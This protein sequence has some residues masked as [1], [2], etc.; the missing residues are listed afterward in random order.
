MTSISSRIVEAS[1]VLSGIRAFVRDY[2]LTSSPI[3]EVDAHV[4]SGQ[5][6][7]LSAASRSGDFD[8]SA[9]GQAAIAQKVEGRSWV[10]VC[11]DNMSGRRPIGTA[12]INLQMDMME[13]GA[14]L[15]LTISN[16]NRIGPNRPL[17]YRL[18]RVLVR[19]ITNAFWDGMNQADVPTAWER[20]HQHSMCA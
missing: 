10:M 1:C 17:P 19:S 20:P 9:A 12:L 16:I 6:Y 14:Q 2:H 11:H 13:R 5:I 7:S 8:I 4:L 18:E 15:V 3:H